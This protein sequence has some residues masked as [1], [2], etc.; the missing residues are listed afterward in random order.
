VRRPAFLA[1]SGA[2]SGRTPWCGT[3]AAAPDATAYPS[4][5]RGVLTAWKI[6]D[7]VWAYRA[8]S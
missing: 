6:Q 7:F 2:G 5:Q 4:W 3:S 1:I 8:G